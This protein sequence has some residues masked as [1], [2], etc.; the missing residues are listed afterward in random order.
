MGEVSAVLLGPASAL[1]DPG[2]RVFWPFLLGALLIGIVVTLGHGVAPRHLARRLLAPRVWLHPSARLDYQLL[3]VK[4]LLRG[5]GLG[6]LGLSMIGVATAVAGSLRRSMGPVALSLSPAAAGALLTLA[7]FLAEDYSRFFVHRLMH[8][9][10]L[11]W[12]F[13]RVHHSAEVL[14][15]LSLYRTHPVE[16]LLNGARGALVVGGLTGLFAYLCGPA[17]R[18]WQVLGVDAIGFAWSLL[19][20]NLRHSHV[21]L[22]YGR[23]LEHVLVS[24]AQHQLHHSRDPRHRDRN[25]GTVLA[26]WDW[27]GGSLHVTEVSGP[28]QPLRFGL[29][30][31][32][33]V[34]RDLRALL[35]S[36][37]S[38]AAHTLVSAPPRRLLPGLC[39]AL[40][41]CLLGCSTPKRLDRGE[42]LGALGQ[43][44]LS[45]YQGARAAADRLVTATAALAAAP[46]DPSR[47]AAR[48]A[49]DSTME[50]WQQAELLR[51]GPAADFET[52]GGK[53]LR[54]QIY[55]WPDVNR[56]LI[57]EQ[58]VSRAYEGALANL[59]VSTRGLAA[60][61]YLLFD[62]SAD[63]GC[64]PAAPI[65]ADGSW[66]ALGADEIARRKAAYASAAAADVA[67]R[68][69][70]LVGAWQEGGFLAQLSGAGRGSTL[71]ATQ[72][73]ALSAVA[74]ALF[75]LDTDVKDA[76]LARPLGLK[77]CAKATCPEALESPWADRGEQHLQK[78]LKGLQLLL[79]G[80]P[81]GMNLGFDDL[82]EA[83]GAPALAEQ[84]R[85]AVAA[86]VAALDAIPG[87]SLRAALADPQG[88]AAMVA[89]HDAVREVTS[90][91]KMEFSMTLAITS[92]RVEGDH[93]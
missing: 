51:Y 1:L 70:A 83:A 77:D 71:F 65:N 90:L 69:Q 30:D 32:E 39:A 8:R 34:Q 11:L 74:E 14:T 50:V 44:S 29:A 9:S 6:A 60:L 52:V 2:R 64:A 24:P 18:G 21:W 15:P 37:F 26:L 25:F 48:A 12:A 57:D 53:G 79:F 54:A 58:L 22:S 67:L 85:V 10:P 4:A 63:N 43:C 45:T 23:R 72:Q 76:R 5:L 36:P 61:E 87:E 47:A 88:R 86:A 20:A 82:L 91:L 80:C 35:L 66:A 38:A 68:L 42:L 16:A 41:L 59:S 62:T 93:D 28:R 92:S 56:C 89:A 55:A 78:N 31:G 49:W 81:A 33:P 3:L 13:H 40:A 19:G 46:S 84:T 17:L 7:V 27:L 73:T 75:Y